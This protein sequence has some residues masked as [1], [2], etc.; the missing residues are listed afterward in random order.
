MKNEK[1]KISN[2][3]LGIAFLSLAFGAC[4]NEPETKTVA[5]ETTEAKKEIS[6][7]AVIAKAEFTIE[8][9]TCAMG[10]AKTI[11]KKL[12]SMEG[13]KSATVD[14]DKKL[15]MVEFDE[16]TVTTS[17]LEETV[18]KAGEAYSV[19]GMKTVESFTTNFAKGECSKD[20]K[21]ENC[22]HKE[23]KA[24]SEANVTGDKKACKADC[25][26]ACCAKK[27]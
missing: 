6:A 7:D 15:A 24:S 17:S 5:I 8:G 25:K 19:S 18:Q 9:M 1:M 26:K 14:F 20:C 21:K 13:V 22:N 23:D 4:K 27:A 3:L 16:A 11:E 12:S 2:V 10:C